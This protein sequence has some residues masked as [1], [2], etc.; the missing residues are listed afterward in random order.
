MRTTTRV[1]LTLLLP[2]LA[3]IGCGNDDPVAEPNRTNGT[4]DASSV[5]PSATGSGGIEPPG[6][7]DHT[8]ATSTPRDAPH[9]PPPPASGSGAVGV[10]TLGPQ[11]PVVQDNVPCP[12]RPAPSARVAISA[13]AEGSTLE[14][15][16]A[17]R[18][19]IDTI[20]ANGAGQFIINVDAGT[21]A[22]TAETPD[23]MTCPVEGITVT[24]RGY[25]AVVVACDTGIR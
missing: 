21:Y 18:T 17:A 22:V 20:E 4:D 6:T 2:A 7:P 12:D 11:C 10:V 15:P 13:L 8:V 24:D 9:P 3:L 16:V 25:T 23:A 19:P 1:G 5:P 14:R